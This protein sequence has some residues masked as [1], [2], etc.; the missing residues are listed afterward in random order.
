MSTTGPQ[1]PPQPWAVGLAPIRDA[2]DGRAQMSALNGVERKHAH[3]ASAEAIWVRVEAIRFG[4]HLFDEGAGA[5]VSRYS[6]C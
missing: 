5:G 6:A 1:L 3:E 2:P 4:K